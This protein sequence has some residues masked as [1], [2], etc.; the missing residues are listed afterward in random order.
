MERGQGLSWNRLGGVEMGD[1][2]G[3]D[4]GTR[5]TTRLPVG[6]DRSNPFCLTLDLVRMCYSCVT[7]PPQPLGPASPAFRMTAEALQVQG[8]GLCLTTDLERTLCLVRLGAWDF[9]TTIPCTF[10]G[11]GRSV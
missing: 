7:F 10:F 2:E 11:A 4:G 9:P 1:R 8:C 3:R 5:D 6:E